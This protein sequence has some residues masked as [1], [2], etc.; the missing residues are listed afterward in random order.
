MD[1]LDAKFGHSEVAT[2]KYGGRQSKME[3]RFDLISP[4]AIMKLAHVLEY[5]SRRYGV[6]NWKVIEVNDHLNHALFHIYAY[7][8]QDSKEDHLSH[9]FARVMMAIEIDAHGLTLPTTD[10][11]IV[12]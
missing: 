9:A 4:T 7:L 6:D 2:N 3:H 8:A 5:G 11:S 12:T 10:S 1:Q